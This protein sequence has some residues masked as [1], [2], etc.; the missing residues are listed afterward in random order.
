MNFDFERQVASDA[1]YINEVLKSLLEKFDCKCSIYE[2]MSYALLSSGKRIRPILLKKTYELLTCRENYSDEVIDYSMAAIE[3][4]HCYSLVHDDLPSMD[5]SDFRR[6]LPTVH[7]KFGEG[8]GVLTGDALLNSAMELMMELCIKHS[9]NNKGIL[10]ASRTLFESSGSLGMIKGQ[11]IDLEAVNKKSRLTEDMLYTLTE[12]KTCALIEAA[13]VMGAHLSM[14]NKATLDA[15]KALANAIGMIFQIQDDILDYDA[16]VAEG[17]LSFATYYG[18]KGAA[19]HRD[20]YKAVAIDRLHEL[21][22][23]IG[24]FDL[25]IEYLCNREK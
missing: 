15:I 2:A 5:N 11:A 4:V 7:K 17:K 10:G 25:M 8:I 19:E 9:Y 12:L 23:G 16:D 18:I 20:R 6:G 13:M 1:A 21:N 24:F 3:M 14:A 22:R